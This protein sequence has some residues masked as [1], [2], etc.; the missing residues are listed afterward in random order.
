MTKDLTKNQKLALELLRSKSPAFV[1]PTEVGRTVGAQI[2]K[3]GNH[4][5][6]GS[7]LCKK[8]VTLGLAERNDAGHYKAIS[9]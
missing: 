8:L 2:G 7:P 5:S 4:S 1:S 6:F 3:P 9:P